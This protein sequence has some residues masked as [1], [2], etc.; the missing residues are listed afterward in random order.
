MRMFPPVS[1]ESYEVK[2]AD[3]SVFRAFWT[4][5]AWWHQ[6]KAITPIGWR[7]SDVAAA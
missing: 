1:C 3:G 6:G 2:L 5:K 7:A 4:G